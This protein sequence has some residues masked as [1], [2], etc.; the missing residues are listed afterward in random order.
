MANRQRTS[1][2]RFKT[3]LGICIL[4]GASTGLLVAVVVPNT[5]RPVEADA[6]LPKAASGSFAAAPFS[7]IVKAT[8]PVSAGEV[9]R[10]LK[11]AH[12]MRGSFL[13]GIASWYGSV[14]DGHRTANGER[15]DMYAMTAC[16]P[17]LPFGS[18]VRVL[19][20]NTRKSVVVRIND[21]GALTPGRVID[22][23]YAAARELE[24]TEQGIAPVSLYV[25]SM[26]RPGRGR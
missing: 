15:F 20:L 25:I 3:Q 11:P 9:S 2:I 12:K 18:M 23:S 7:V 5:A 17:T 21:R 14:L 19:N 1:S 6:T 10:A 22:L 24:I 8:L 4:A 16:H 26:G 13:R